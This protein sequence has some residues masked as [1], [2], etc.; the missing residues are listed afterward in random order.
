MAKP[1]TLVAGAPTDTTTRRVLEAHDLVPAG[2][3]VQRPPLILESDGLLKRTGK[4]VLYVVLSPLI[5]IYIVVDNVPA[6]LAG[7]WKMLERAMS[8]LGEGLLF[9]VEQ[10]ARGV[11]AGARMVGKAIAALEDAV[12]KYVIV[13]LFNGAAFVLKQTGRAVSWTADMIHQFVLTP[14]AKGAAVTGR[15]LVTV[16]QATFEGLSMVAEALA[17]YVLEPMLRAGYALGVVVNR[18]VLKPLGEGVAKVLEVT[19]NGIGKVLEAAASVTGWTLHY[20]FKGIGWTLHYTFKGMSWVGGCLY[21]VGAVTHK[22]VLVPLYHAAVAVGDVIA[23]GLLVTADAV[24]RALKAVLVPLYHGIQATFRAVGK[25]LHGVW[26]GV[27]NIGK[28]LHKR[29]LVPLHHGVTALLEAIGKG[30]AYTARGVY[31][32]LLKPIGTL[33][34]TVAIALRDA[35]KSIASAVGRVIVSLADR[36]HQHVLK[37]IGHVLAAAAAVTTVVII[38]V[39]GAV[40]KGAKA[41]GGVVKAAG[42]AVAKG[43]KDISGAIADG[44]RATSKNIKGAARAV[45]KFVKDMFGLSPKVG[46]SPCPETPTKMPFTSSTPFTPTPPTSPRRTT[47]PRR[48]TESADLCAKIPAGN[49]VSADL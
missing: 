34:Q 22:R 39:A 6:A 33:I 47:S 46:K 27:C 3:P 31:D 10:L 42:K 20:T 5:A 19:L 2:E 48:V 35:G 30:A 49:L 15:A 17:S 9:T 12:A 21:D 18:T 32:Y 45:S 36:V 16:I 26:S 13:P 43:A 24:E 11:A 28:T 4:V 29:V 1:I 38:G 41:T 37:P 14:L 23:A 25:L 8:R 44:A 40:A 7:A